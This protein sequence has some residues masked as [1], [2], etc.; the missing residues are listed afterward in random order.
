M[1]NMPATIPKDIGEDIWN[2]GEISIFTPMKVRITESPY[3]SLL[4][5]WIKL[6]NRKYKDLKPSIANIFDV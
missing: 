2:H 1:I 3:G 6:D 4:N 5:I